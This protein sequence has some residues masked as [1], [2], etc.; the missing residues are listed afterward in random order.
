MKIKPVKQSTPP[1]YPVKE[2]VA[3]QQ[4]K[5]QVPKRWLDNKAAKVA[6]GALAA[7]TLAGCETPPLAGVPAPPETTIP[8]KSPAPTNDEIID[9]TIMGEVMAPTMMVAPLFVHGGGQGAFGCVMVAPPVFLTESEALEVIND[10]AKDY[11]LVFSMENSPELSGVLEPVTN[12]YGDEK[13]YPSQDFVTVKA[14]FADNQHGVAIEFVSTK[15]VSGWHRDVGEEISAGTY[16]TKDAAQQ[17]CGAFANAISSN[18][19]ISA[20]GVLYDPCETSKDSEKQLHEILNEESYEKLEQKTR[21]F[22]QQSRA[23]SEQQLKKQAV[24]FFEWLKEQ[25]II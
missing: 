19:D 5:S 24:D 6:L 7:M 10:A 21:E 20:A 12:L 25:G 4:I 13:N 23:M 9:Y 18:A 17:L 3:E 8:T 15:D 14:D 22:E 11:G 16:D 2:D 1:Q